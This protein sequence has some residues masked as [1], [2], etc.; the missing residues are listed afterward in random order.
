M[1]QLASKAY[2]EITHRTA[3]EKQIE[4]A[5]FQQITHNLEK[6]APAARPAPAVWAGA[7]DRN[8]Q[9]WTVLASDLL[10]PENSLPVETKQGLL[11]LALFVRRH[12]M[13]VLSG[14][15]D[16][17]DLIE[18]NRTIMDG[19]APAGANLGEVAA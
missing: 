7:I 3:S 16:L 2:G 17:A 14:E 12:S 8:L 19:I 13:Q 18:V 10:L 1:Q 5:L 11:N 4:F 15:A 6:V 9:L